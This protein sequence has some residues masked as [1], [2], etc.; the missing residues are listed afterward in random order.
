[1]DN[2]KELDY[3]LGEVNPILCSTAKGEVDRL[4]QDTQQKLSD[5]KHKM[6]ELLNHHQ[7]LLFLSMPKLLQLYKLIISTNKDNKKRNDMIV[8]EVSLL[9]PN[10]SSEQKKL[11][12]S[13]EVYKLG[14]NANTE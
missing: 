10:N 13:V 8:Q 4:V 1:M 11:R 6:S 2:L 7:W 9:V 12:A 5:W 14:C 3:P